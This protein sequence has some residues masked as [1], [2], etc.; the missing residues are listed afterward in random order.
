MIYTSLLFYFS[1]SFRGLFVILKKLFLSSS[2]ICLYFSFLFF[3][4][5][6]IYLYNNKL[7]PIFNNFFIRCEFFISVK[8]FSHNYILYIK[9]FFRN[10]TLKNKS[11]MINDYKG[12]YN[13]N[14]NLSMVI[15]AMK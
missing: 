1:L 15:N 7:T 8:I 14:V 5:S 13:Q 6:P 3:D 9:I 2:G 10:I 4:L 11:N 12:I